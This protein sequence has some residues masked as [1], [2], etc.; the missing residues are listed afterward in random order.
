MAARVVLNRR[1]E[2]RHQR[3]PPCNVGP[4]VLA[5]ERSDIVIAEK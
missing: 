2:I 4:I 1:A 3:E 5:F